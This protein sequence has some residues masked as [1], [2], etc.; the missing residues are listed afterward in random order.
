MINPET[1]E[2]A[3]KIVA[4]MVAHHPQNKRLLRFR[5]GGQ[6]YRD[7]VKR[8]DFERRRR[9]DL[10]LFRTGE[11]TGTWQIAYDPDQKVAAVSLAWD[12]KRFSIRRYR[13]EDRRVYRLKP[14]GEDALVEAR[15]RGWV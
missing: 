5:E 8:G 15:L 3:Y 4:E 1:L 10:D 2:R 13:E 11:L 12:A 6:H 9:F 14:G 7:Q